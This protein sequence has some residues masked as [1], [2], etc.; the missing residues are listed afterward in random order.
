[1]HISPSLM[2]CM[3]EEISVIQTTS[4][5]PHGT[6]Q[7]IMMFR[8]TPSSRH[9]NLTCLVHQWKLIQATTESDSGSS[10]ILL[11]TKIVLYSRI[12]QCGGNSVTI[13]HINVQ[14]WV[15]FYQLF[16]PTHLCCSNLVET[17]LLDLLN[18][19]WRFFCVY[20]IFFPGNIYTSH[21]HLINI[22]HGN[23]PPPKSSI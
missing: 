21:V 14:L 8:C 3:K 1:M 17:I 12:S 4:R 23:P 19:W 5:I 6:C 22:A 20:T 10:A 13:G 11:T 9:K 2:G 15:Q 7:Q 16:L 18:V